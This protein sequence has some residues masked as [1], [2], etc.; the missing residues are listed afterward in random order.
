VA[1]ATGSPDGRTA[2]VTLTA[3]ARIPV[4]NFILPDG[5]PI[6]ATSSARARLLK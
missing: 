3:V 6:E 1:A 5:V 2:T 4:V